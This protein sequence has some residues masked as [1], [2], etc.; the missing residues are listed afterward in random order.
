[1]KQHRNHQRQR[2]TK[3]DQFTEAMTQI[4]GLS[5]ELGG[6]SQLHGKLHRRSLGDAVEP[7]APIEAR[8]L[9]WAIGLAIYVQIGIHQETVKQLSAGKAVRGRKRKER[10]TTA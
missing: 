9:T 1:M 4:I 6:L 3:H 5:R 8:L 2:Q 10:R 7:L